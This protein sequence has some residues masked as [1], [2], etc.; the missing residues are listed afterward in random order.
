[1]DARAPISKRQDAL[2]TLLSIKDPELLL[3]LQDLL[4]DSSLRGPALR[5][6][7]A[8][9]DETTPKLILRHYSSFTDVEKSDA[10]QTLAS[11]PAYALALLAALER[12][13]VARRDLSAFTARQLL[14]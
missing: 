2:L 10:V 13:Q 9:A 7:A 14:P 8:Y 6:L 11:R 4:M 5:G 3:L 12:G 1:M